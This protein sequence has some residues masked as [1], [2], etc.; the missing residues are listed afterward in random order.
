MTERVTLDTGT[1]S[2]IDRTL[3]GK[4]TMTY[5][6]NPDSEAPGQGL[7]AFGRGSAFP[8]EWGTPPGTRFSEERAAWVLARVAEQ[9]A[10]QTVRRRALASRA[11]R[12][13]HGPAARALLI[14]RRF[15]PGDAA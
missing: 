2:S 4:K 12:H 11:T 5:Q 14:H 13:L 7:A 6:L 9:R 10:L 8:L 1:A 15:A 3:E